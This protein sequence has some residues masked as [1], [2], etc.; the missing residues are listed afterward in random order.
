MNKIERG[1]K[2]LVFENQKALLYGSYSFGTIV[3]YSDEE[4]NSLE[5]YERLY[6]VKDEERENSFFVSCR[7]GED[8]LT[9]EDYR[10]LLLLDIKNNNYKISE[11]L[12]LNRIFLDKITK[13]DKEIE[14]KYSKEDNHENSLKKH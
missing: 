14:E 12:D 10:N 3:D 1:T 9:P 2:V 7:Y 13:L 5:D 11:L 4:D 6:K 8:I